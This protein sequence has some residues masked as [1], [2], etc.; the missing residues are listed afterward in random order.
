[1]RVRACESLEGLEMFAN[2]ACCFFNGTAMYKRN[3]LAKGPASP[4]IAG[5]EMFV[6]LLL[7]LPTVGGY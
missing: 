4:L 7:I 6:F 3:L 5:N 2:A 1:M